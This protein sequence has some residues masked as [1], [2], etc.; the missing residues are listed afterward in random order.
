M[1]CDMTLFTVEQKKLRIRQKFLYIK[2]V[3]I[4][5]VMKITPVMFELAWKAEN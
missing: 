4:S 5:A 1:V 3:D 2:N